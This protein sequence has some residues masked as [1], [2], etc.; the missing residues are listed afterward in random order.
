MGLCASSPNDVSEPQQVLKSKSINGSAGS[1]ATSSGGSF[2]LKTNSE[3]DIGAGAQTINPLNRH[4]R[5]S[6]A[7]NISVDD[8]DDI[9]SSENDD[10]TASSSSEDEEIIDDWLENGPSIPVA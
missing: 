5:T 4:A 7:M 3:L 8:D 9:A 2:L 10:C 1:S 6:I